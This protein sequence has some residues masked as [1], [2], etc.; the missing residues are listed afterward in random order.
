MGAPPVP[1]TGPAARR[2]TGRPAT[3]GCPGQAR[4]LDLLP[5]DATDAASL[6]TAWRV[7]PHS[8]RVPLGVGADG[9]PYVVDLAT[10]GPH[11]LVAGTTGS[12]KSELLQS[13]VA[14][15]AV[16]NRPDRMSFVLIDYKGG[17]AFRDCAGL[18]HTVGM[19]T[20]LDGHLTERALQSLGAELRRRE[21]LLRAAGCTDLD[22]YLTRDRGD[23]ADGGDSADLAAAP[24][25]RPPMARLV[26]VVDEFATL[27]DELPDFVGG[28]VGI[29]Q[30]GRSL[31]VH[32]VLA[33]QRPSGVVSADIRANTGLRIALRVTDPAESRDVVD[34]RDAADISR[35]TPGRAV[36]RTGTAGVSLVQTARVTGRAV[37]HD[38]RPTCRRVPWE[39]VG[40]P[41]PA[42]G[43]ESG[44]RSVRPQPASSPRP[45]R[46]PAASAPPRHRARGCPRC[47]AWS[48]PTTS[49]AEAGQDRGGVPIASS[50][51]PSRAASRA[52][53]LPARPR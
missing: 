24:R 31:G 26:L 3:R 15:L 17:A 1:R 16:A 19:V 8:T 48:P 52:R 23:R 4:L 5:A 47:P 44:R 25:G 43:H 36:A 39:V 13:L 53:H 10:D 45:P 37:A 18:P 6:E 20:D 40:D 42:V 22:S 35:S 49:I 21:Q 32:L 29:A 27:V 12:G 7:E 33:T 9:E 28:L 41:R 14:G 38:A 50:R 46:P 11:V 34:V 30:R 51:R 2:D